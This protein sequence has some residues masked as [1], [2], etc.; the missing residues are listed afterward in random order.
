MKLAA[1]VLVYV[2]LLEDEVS[3]YEYTAVVFVGRAG[4]RSDGV[5]REE[6]VFELRARDEMESGEVLEVAADDP[7]AEEDIQRMVQRLGHELLSLE[8]EEGKI[9]ILIRKK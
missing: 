2:V 8:V 7:A 4:I 5:A 3:H 6:F 1:V 9:R